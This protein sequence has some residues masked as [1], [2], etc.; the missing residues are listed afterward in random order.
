MNDKAIKHRPTTLIILD[1]WGYSESSDA[2]AIY[3]ANTP[4]W[5]QLWNNHPHGF[6]HGS[7]NKV[8]LPD[9]QM[10]NSEVGHLNLGAGRVVYQN[11]SRINEAIKTAA[12]MKTKPSIKPLIMQSIMTRPFISQ[13]YSRLA[14]SIATRIKSMRPLN[15]L[16]KEALA[17]SIYMPS[18]MAEIPR[19]NQPPTPLLPP[20]NSLPI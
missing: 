16:P 14:V 1:G 5:D 17:R 2:N 4:V 18:L 19:Q 13:A 3:H 7:G 6:I 10:G 8:G 9:D 20:N 11:I 12:S 15:R